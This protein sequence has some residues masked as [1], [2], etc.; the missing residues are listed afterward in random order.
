MTLA[1]IDSSQS[2]ARPAAR[3]QGTLA[4]ALQEAL[5]VVIRLR[6][7]RQ[8]AADAVSFRTHV[9]QLLASA[10]QHARRAGYQ[11]EHVKLAVYAYV[12]FLDESILNSQQPMFASWPSQPLQEEI[13]GDHIAGENFFHHLD[14]LL[15]AQDSAETADVLEVYLICLL[16]GF[17]G[18][19][20]LGDP[21]GLQGR[22]T[23]VQEKILRCRGPFGELAPAWA[24]PADEVPPS[25][26]DP[27]VTRLGVVAGLALF[28][29]L[30]LYIG[31]RM[32]LATD[33]ATLQALTAQL[34]P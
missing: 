17:R 30:A 21:S 27:W 15:A 25:R 3:A 16:L 19:Y 34:V 8:V 31:F 29:V 26:R 20:T 32:A 13:F 22:I 11:G 10:D 24:L 1:T 6:A 33:I 2:T 12:A 9:K 5:T 18:R 7:N 14:A 28:A 4:L 23:A